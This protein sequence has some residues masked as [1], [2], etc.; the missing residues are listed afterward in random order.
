MINANGL[1]SPA[2]HPYLGSRHEPN[3]VNSAP[4][5]VCVCSG[6]DL[7]LANIHVVQARRSFVL[8]TR[9]LRNP[10]PSADWQEHEMYANI[11][12]SSDMPACICS[13]LLSTYLI[14]YGVANMLRI[15]QFQAIG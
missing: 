8:A 2:V 1:F 11:D 7:I 14:I 6:L 13:P 3:L 10:I 9:R 5:C 12:L 4:G 15:G